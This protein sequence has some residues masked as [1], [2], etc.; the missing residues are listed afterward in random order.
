MEE[1]AAGESTSLRPRRRPTRG[2]YVLPSLLTAG[3]IALGFY[4]ITQSIQASQG[5]PSFSIERR[6]RSASRFSSM[7]W[8]AA[9]HG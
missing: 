3:N 6:W 8:T 2:M 4:A 5:D 7:V 9:S 1:L